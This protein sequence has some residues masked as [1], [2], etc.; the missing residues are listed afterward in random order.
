MRVLVTLLLTLTEELADFV[1]VPLLLTLL[2]GVAESEGHA[3][4]VAVGVADVVFVEEEEEDWLASAVADLVE[5]VEPVTVGVGDTVVDVRDEEVSLAETV[6]LEVCRGEALAE[7]TV[8][9][10]ADTLTEAVVDWLTVGSR[11]GDTEPVPVFEAD[12]DEDTVVVGVGDL[13]GLTEGWGWWR[14]AKSGSRRWTR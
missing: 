9:E 6:E 13:E 2:L 14:P 1:E 8:V 10:D 7:R 3:V 11:D 12:W 5:D 4:R